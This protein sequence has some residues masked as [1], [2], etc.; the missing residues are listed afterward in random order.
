MSL[1]YCPSCGELIEPQQM[2][3]A[4]GTALCTSCGRLSRLSDIVRTTRPVAEILNQPP[5]GCWVRR[6]GDTIV[7]HA[8]LRSV[9]RAIGRLAMAIFWNSI[10]SLFVLFALA[11]L[12][13]SLIGP[14]PPWWPG[15][16]MD[17]PI[18]LGW[19]LVFCVFLIPFVLAGAELV[20]EVLLYAAGKVE[21]VIHGEDAH[22]RTGIASLVWRRR[23]DPTQVTRVFEEVKNAATNRRAGVPLVIEADREVKFGSKLTLPRQE[24]MRAVLQ[25]L[26]GQPESPRREEVLSAARQVF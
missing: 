14:L 17:E 23:F 9:G 20:I 6:Y 7:A 8:S 19:A 11:A 13:A 15:P 10:V 4:E 26:L 5:S 1:N 21:V 12:Y 25:A 22:I 16:D 3:L 24:W 2:N 18:P